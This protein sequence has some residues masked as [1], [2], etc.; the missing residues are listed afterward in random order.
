M[1]RVPYVLYDVKY[2]DLVSPGVFPGQNQDRHQLDPRQKWATV[3][4]LG[5]HALSY[6]ARINNELRPGTFGV[7]APLS[8]RALSY[9]ARTNYGLRPGTFG[10]LT[11]L[12]YQGYQARRYHA[13]INSKLR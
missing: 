6:H 2:I 11:S 10:V 4:P 8:C 7:L 3:G 5:Y 1:G 9:H 12:S 13:R